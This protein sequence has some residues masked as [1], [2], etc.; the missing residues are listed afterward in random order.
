MGKVKQKI[1]IIIKN[2]NYNYKWSDLPSQ[3]SSLYIDIYKLGD[4][5]KHMLKIIDNNN[6]HMNYIWNMYYTVHS[7]TWAHMYIMCQQYI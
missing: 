4:G 3:K 6:T 1:H 5:Y 7:T 2:P